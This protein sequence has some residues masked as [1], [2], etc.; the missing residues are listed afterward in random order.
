MGHRATRVTSAQGHLPQPLAE[1]NTSSS[2]PGTRHSA[3]SS[4]ANKKYRDVTQKKTRLRF[5]TG[6]LLGLAAS[7]A[8]SSPKGGKIEQFSSA[9]L[10]CHCMCCFQE[11]CLD[12]AGD[13]RDRQ[14][15]RRLLAS[16]LLRQHWKWV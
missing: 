7:K 14:G 15:H 9:V 3:V 2:S 4:P 6:L 8:T 16:L 5:L 1:I 10:A 13:R 12:R 11:G